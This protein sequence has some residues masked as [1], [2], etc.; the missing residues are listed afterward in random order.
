MARDTPSLL[1]NHLHSFRHKNSAS[2]FKAELQANPPANYHYLI[3]SDSLSSLQSICER[4]STHPSVQRVHIITHLISTAIKQVMVNWIQSWIRWR[5]MPRP[6][7]HLSPSSDLLTS[8]PANA[9]RMKKEKTSLNKLAVIKLRLRV[10]H[11]HLTYA[12][13]FIDIPLPTTY[14]HRGN[15]GSHSRSPFHMFLTSFPSRK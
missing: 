4:F 9:R 13:L 5:S 2:I 3:L 12:Y 7:P 6:F 15:D 10:G 11:T 1:M 8:S 14:S